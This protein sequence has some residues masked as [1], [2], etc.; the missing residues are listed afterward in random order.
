LCTLA[1]SSGIALASDYGH[2]D[3]S[4]S[5]HHVQ[6][7]DETRD[8]DKSDSDESDGIRSWSADDDESGD[9]RDSG[10]DRPAVSRGGK[11]GAAGSNSEDC[12]PALA[13]SRGTN[14]CDQTPARQGENGRDYEGR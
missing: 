13:L 1:A 7:G 3:D 5:G 11:G 14:E 12:G 4:R 6:H 9:D 10:D 8:S 2:R